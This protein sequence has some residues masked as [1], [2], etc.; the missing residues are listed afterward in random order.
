VANDGKRKGGRKGRKR[1]GG[2]YEPIRGPRVKRAA[3]KEPTPEPQPLP[4]SAPVGLGDPNLAGDG[5]DDALLILAALGAMDSLEPDL[6]DFC[7]DPGGEASVSIVERALPFEAH[8]EEAEAARAIARTVGRSRPR[9]VPE[10]QPQVGCLGPIE[11]AVVEIFEGPVSVPAPAAAGRKKT[12]R[13]KARPVTRRFFK[14]LT[15]DEKG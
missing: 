2:A 4:A 15:G 9:N 8:Y 11:E 7:D 1:Q 3:A 13:K 5:V 14:A 12:K 10:T 6:P